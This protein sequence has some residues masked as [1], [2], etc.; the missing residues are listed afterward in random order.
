MVIL[1]IGLHQLHHCI[2]DQLSKCHHLGAK[3]NIQNGLI[4]SAIGLSLCAE[5]T[6][7]TAINSTFMKDL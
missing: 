1:A 5:A 6:Q 2:V 3:H 7:I 4:L